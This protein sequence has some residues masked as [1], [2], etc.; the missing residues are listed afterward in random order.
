M[1]TTE[2]YNAIKEELVFTVGVNHTID[3]AIAC[4]W[5][6]LFA[7]EMNKLQLY[8]VH[9]KKMAACLWIH[10]APLTMFGFMC[11]NDTPVTK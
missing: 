4:K 6:W 9:A 3:W 11:K 10:V 7:T 5:A 2:I 1:D 8:D